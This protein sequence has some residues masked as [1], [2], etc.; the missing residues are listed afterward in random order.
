MLFSDIDFGNARLKYVNRLLNEYSESFDFHF[1]NSSLLKTIYDTQKELLRKEE[2]YQL[3][4]AKTIELINSQ[5]TTYMQKLNEQ[6]DEF[7]RQ[8]R[9]LN[10]EITKLRNDFD[11]LK[12]EHTKLQNENTENQKIINELNSFKKEITQK[13]KQEEE[14]KKKLLNQ[15]LEFKFSKGKEFDGILQ[16]IR[17]SGDIENE[18][19]AT[20]SSFY[21][22]NE[23][24]YGPRNI[25]NQYDYFATRDV[26]DSW[27]CFD[28][29]SRF[30]IPS[31]YTIKSIVG[32]PNHFY[33]K[34]WIFE[35]STDTVS[36]ENLD[37][38]KDCPHLNGNGNIYTFKIQ[39]P[40]SKAFRYLRIRQTGL[41]WQGSNILGFRDIEIF[42]RLI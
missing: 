14:E 11:Q 25:L 8:I 39:N 28:F 32:Y 29:K 42:G 9:E 26:S 40:P 27:I 18:I 15:G 34:S 30:I 22:N 3:E 17:N 12:S 20:T 2:K 21:K 41:N 6:K 36:W 16:H 24:I 1:I 4:Q 7:D 37:E 35:G 31:E 10:N 33:L 23:N 19:N 13:K 38:E 5:K